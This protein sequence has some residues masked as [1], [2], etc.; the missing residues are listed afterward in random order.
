VLSVR[1]CDWNLCDVCEEVLLDICEV[2]MGDSLNLVC[3]V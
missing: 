2:G 1:N 3:C